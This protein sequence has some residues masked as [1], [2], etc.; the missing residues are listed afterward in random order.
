MMRSNRRTCVDA[1]LPALIAGVG[2]GAVFASAFAVAG[3]RAEA[4]APRWPRV[5]GAVFA[6]RNADAVAPVTAFDSKGR[7]L[8]AFNCVTRGRALFGRCYEL[9]CDGGSFHAK[10]AGAW[11]GL[12]AAKSGA[13]TVEA[14]VTPAEAAPRAGGIVLAFGD[15]KGEDLALLHDE[16]GLSLRLG[17]TRAVGLFALEAGNPA[18]VVIACDT[19]KWAAYRDGKLVRSGTP[20]AGA[21]SWGTRQLV[22]GAAWSGAGAWRGRLEGI[23]VFPRVLTSE[24][25]A[26]ESAAS[27]AFM[28]ERRPA[29]T[30][31]FRGALVRQAKTAGLAE[32]R[33]YTRS[34]SVAEY[35]VAQVLEGE[36]KEPTIAVL[37]WMIMDGKR[38][39]IADR[40]PGTAVELR[41]ERL[42][43]H[44]QLESCRRDELDGE[45]PADL[46]YCESETMP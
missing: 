10:D 34:M 16:A 15:D 2:L 25:A 29:A 22:M 36:W 24:E 7:D 8:M 30:I 32:I 1:A 35:K 23:A 21:P 12:Q 46:F 5:S 3:E 6:L 17:G 11:V 28:A 31:R 44:P 4:Q 37:H 33:P 13:F 43:D 27:K 41:V 42:E 9:V 14:M 39:P 45:I 40:P 18:H 26:G 38:L 20:P 19:R